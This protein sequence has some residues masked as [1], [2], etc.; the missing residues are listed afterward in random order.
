MCC[1][2]EHCWILEQVKSPFLMFSSLLFLNTCT[3]SASSSCNRTSCLIVLVRKIMPFFFCSLLLLQCHPWHF[4]HSGHWINL[5]VFIEWL[6]E[7]KRL[8]NTSQP[9]TSMEVFNILFPVS[10]LFWPL[11]SWNRL[12]NSERKSSKKRVL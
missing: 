9:V 3:G 5:Y 10:Y 7:W 8:K 12:V 2:S 6:R 11:V 1:Q 4:I